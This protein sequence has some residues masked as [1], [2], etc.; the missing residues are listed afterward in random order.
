[1]SHFIRQNELK[2]DMLHSLARSQRALADILETISPMARSSEQTA[3]HLLSLIEALNHY[4]RALASKLCILPIRQ[5][6]IGKP[7]KPW[8]ASKPNH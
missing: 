7:G 3:E 5:V 6:K 1:M 2:L 8:F 4:Q